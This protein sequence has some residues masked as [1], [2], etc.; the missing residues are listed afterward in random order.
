MIKTVVS[1]APWPS[2]Q[3]DDPG[4]RHGRVVVY[5]TTDGKDEPLVRWLKSYLEPPHP[6]PVSP[7]ALAFR[8]AI[9]T[10]GTGGNVCHHARIGARRPDGRLRDMQRLVADMKAAIKKTE[11]PVQPEQQNAS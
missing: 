11:L 9:E 3:T 5:V 6:C 7:G 4:G 1:A 2:E 8:C 10:M